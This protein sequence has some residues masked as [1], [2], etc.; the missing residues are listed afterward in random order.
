MK[1]W[2]STKTRP[3]ESQDRVGMVILYVAEGAG[4]VF[5]KERGQ[6][7]RDALKGFDVDVLED[8]ARQ[9]VKHN[10][11]RPVVPGHLLTWY[12]KCAEDRRLAQTT[13]PERQIGEDY[14]PPE[15]AKARIA[16]LRRAVAGRMRA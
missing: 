9:L 1:S 4:E 13:P 8:A 11:V 16:E 10:T 6:V 12:H 3:G 2:I 14:L 7:W 5:S 15:Q